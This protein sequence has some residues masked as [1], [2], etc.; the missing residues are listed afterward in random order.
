VRRCQQQQQQCQQAVAVGGTLPNLLPCDEFDDA[1][2]SLC[3]LQT[4]AMLGTRGML[5]GAVDK[6]KVV[7]QRRSDR[8][9]SRNTAAARPAQHGSQLALTFSCRGAV[10]SFL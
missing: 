7:S 3:L 1:Y 10:V 5:G 6:F 2:M 9:A 8:G 4:D